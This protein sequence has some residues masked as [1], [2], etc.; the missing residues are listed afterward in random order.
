M[1]TYRCTAKDGRKYYASA[2]PPQC[3][4]RPGQGR[5]VGSGHLTEEWT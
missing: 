3:V 2:I 1:A 4:G 5:L